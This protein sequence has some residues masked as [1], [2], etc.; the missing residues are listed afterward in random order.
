M[1][2]L[3]LFLTRSPRKEFVHLTGANDTNVDIDD[4]TD[5]EVIEQFHMSAAARAAL[6]KSPTVNQQRLKGDVEKQGGR[7]GRLGVLFGPQIDEC[8]FEPLRQQSSVASGSPLSVAFAGRMLYCASGKSREVLLFRE[9]QSMERFR[10]NLGELDVQEIIDNKPV[11]KYKG[12]V[13]LPSSA[14]PYDICSNGGREGK[15]QKH[16]PPPRYLRITQPPGIAPR[17]TSLQRNIL[18]HQAPHVG[19]LTGCISPRPIGDEAV[20]ANDGKNK[21]CLA[22]SEILNLIHAGGNKGKLF[23]LP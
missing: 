8:A 5:Q 6:R 21:S 12:F 1:P 11:I 13:A 4:L 7:W 10:S 9:Y 2:H 20:Y 22:M 15:L 17:L 3:T 23:V 16:V 14:T 19:W 18:I